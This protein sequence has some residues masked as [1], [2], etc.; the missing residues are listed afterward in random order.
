MKNLNWVRKILFAG[1]L[2]LQLNMPCVL[3]RGAPGDLDHSFYANLGADGR[4]NAIALQPDGK[5]I[6]GGTRMMV[7][8]LAN[9]AIARIQS[10][11]SVDPSF[12]VDPNGWITDVGAILLLPD[13][14]LLVGYNN[15]IIRLNPGGTPDTSFRQPTI[16][17][18]GVFTGVGSIVVQPDGKTLIGGLFRKVDDIRRDGIARLNTDGSL[19]IS[20]NPGKGVSNPLLLY[21]AVTSI[22]LQPDG[23][24]LIAGNF[25]HVHETSRNGIA[26]LNPDG[27]LDTSFAPGTGVLEVASLALQPDGRILIAGTFNN[28]NSVSRNSV[29]RLNANGSV[30]SSFDPG[31]GLD[32]G[33]ALSMA[34]QSDGKP[35][36]GGR[37]LTINGVD[38]NHIARLNTNGS[39]DGSFEPSEGPHPY[40][41][42]LALQRDGKVIFGGSDIDGTVADDRV[43]TR[44]HGNFPAPS[45]Q[46]TNLHNFA[47]YHG[48]GAAPVGSLVLSGNIL[49][50]TTA[51][52]GSHGYGT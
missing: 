50:G 46:F 4:V 18:D 29:A 22:A 13:G 5:L 7:G 42:A 33:Y 9:Q 14:K 40:I 34:L 20:F 16:I 36:I 10:D 12:A 37:F 3:T 47:D 51:Q 35:V 19:D 23:K 49:Y 43:L 15:G 27:S 25:S 31:S 1:T 2:L 41:F 17:N 32:G 21:T 11:G 8:G 45:P 38:R 6:I 28:V 48:E 52:G 26:R 30:D 24:A 44:L 39:L